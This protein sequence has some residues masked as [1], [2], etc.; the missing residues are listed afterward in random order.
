MQFQMLISSFSL[1]SEELTDVGTEMIDR[2]TAIR[3]RQ[4]IIESLLFF[5]SMC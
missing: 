4:I 3:R 1:R 5:G 2:I